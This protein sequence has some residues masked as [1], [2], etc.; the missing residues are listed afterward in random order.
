MQGIH[1]ILLVAGILAAGCSNQSPGTGVKIVRGTLRYYPPDVKS[2]PAWLGHNF[3][4]GD[5]PI[6]AT[7]LVPEDALKTLVGQVVIVRGTWQPGKQ[8]KPSQDEAANT[9]PMFPEEHVV[10]CGDGLR[11]SSITVEKK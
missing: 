3:M 5:T 10:I 2:V 8:R 4:V 1:V 11:A 6:L 7:E 9:A